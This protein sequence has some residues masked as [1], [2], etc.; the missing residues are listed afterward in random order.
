MTPKCPTCQRQEIDVEELTQVIKSEINH[1]WVEDG[2]HAR[3]FDELFNMN[4]L[5][6]PSSIVCI[7]GFKAE[8]VEDKNP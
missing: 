8:I 7:T 6:G 3:S 1:I 5:G 2:L 4:L